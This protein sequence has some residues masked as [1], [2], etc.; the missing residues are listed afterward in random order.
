MEADPVRHRGPG[1]SRIPKAAALEGGVQ[2]WGGEVQLW[3]PLGTRRACTGYGVGDRGLPGFWSQLEVC[4]LSGLQNVPGAL[5]A[6]VS[7]TKEAS[8][9]LQLLRINPAEVC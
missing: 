5:Q 3:P 7:L 9:D 6:L 8:W 2:L 4:W 1:R